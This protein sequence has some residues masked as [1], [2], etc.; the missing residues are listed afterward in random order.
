MPVGHAKMPENI[1]ERWGAHDSPRHF[2]I[3]SAP[4]NP[5]VYH[6][7]SPPLVYSEFGSYGEPAE[8]SIVVFK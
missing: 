8:R 6:R 5:L 4:Y 1:E 3:V 2:I 7:I